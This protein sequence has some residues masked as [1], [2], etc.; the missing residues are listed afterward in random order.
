MQSTQKFNKLLD[1]ES[2]LL[3][4]V[5]QISMDTK[6]S[7]FCHLNSSSQPSSSNIYLLNKQAN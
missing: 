2:A 3:Y 5:I 1:N 7:Q 4:V 6:V